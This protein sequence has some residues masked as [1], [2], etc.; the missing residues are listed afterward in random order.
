MCH[1]SYYTS[2]AVGARSVCVRQRAPRTLSFPARLALELLWP[3][4]TS[5]VKKAFIIS[6][7]DLRIVAFIRY[8]Q[9]G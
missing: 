2:Y 9:G 3:R 4:A 8:R 7:G 5:S 1:V 6:T